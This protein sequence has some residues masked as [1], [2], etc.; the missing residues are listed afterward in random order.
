M[1]SHPEYIQIET[2]TACNA[3]CPFCPHS[4][5]NERPKRMADDVW[6][7][8][9]D[10]TSG[11]GITYRPFLINEPLSDHRLADIMSYIRRDQTARIELNTNGALM[12]EDKAREILDI[13]IDYIRFSIDGFSKETFERS[14]VGVDFDLTVE[15]TVRFIE[16]ARDRGIVD[17]VEVRMIDME[18]NRHEHQAFIDYW[19]DTGAGAT[20]TELYNWPWD[21]DVEPVELP[22][23]K[24]L[25][26]M[27]FY[28]DGKVSLCCWDTHGR[29]VIGDVTREHA[30]DIWNGE[31]NRRYRALLAQG[32]RKEI[33]LCSRCDAYKKH[34]FEG[35]PPPVPHA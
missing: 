16:L 14:R 13:G 32:K 24:I 6:R 27:F 25:K 21:P 31:I 9:I 3:K 23:K 7:K 30:L 4:S 11:L 34:H 28:V 33:L 17:R 2:T 12:K 5:L 26:E 1:H 15:R 35:F 29:G 22:C 10:E 19:T 8:I 18:Y 20:I